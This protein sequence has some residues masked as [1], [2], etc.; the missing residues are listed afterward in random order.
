[1]TGSMTI[2]P[3]ITNTPTHHLSPP[4]STLDQVAPNTN[5]KSASTTDI[6]FNKSGF[7]VIFILVIL[8]TVFMA[9][10]CLFRYG[11]WYAKHKSQSSDKTRNSPAEKNSTIA[12]ATGTSKMF[13]ISMLQR[14]ELD[15]V[16]QEILEIGSSRRDTVS[17]LEARRKNMQIE[18]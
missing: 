10:Y 15:A 8:S 13:W 1:V 14:P 4:E 12:S 17:E 18:Q 7:L 2:L 3:V 6:G 16:S 11:K 5:A 9:A